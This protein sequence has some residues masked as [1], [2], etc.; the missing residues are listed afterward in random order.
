M[1][2]N[3]LDKKPGQLKTLIDKA[4]GNGEGERCHVSCKEA[5]RILGTTETIVWGLVKAKHLKTSFKMVDGHKRNTFEKASI[6]HFKRNYMLSRVIADR[7][8]VARQSI[9]QRLRTL[10]IYPISGPSINGA[11]T[12]V[13]K[14]SD[15]SHLTKPKVHAAKICSVKSIGL[16]RTKIDEKDYFTMKSAAKYLDIGMRAVT[17]LTQG[18]VLNRVDLPH[19]NVLIER[20]S[21]YKLIK[22]INDPKY[23]RLQ[24]IRDKSALSPTVFW[25]YFINTGIV[26]IVQLFSWQLVHERCVRKLDAL[27]LQYVTET[28]GNKMLGKGSGTLTS[29]RKTGEV[30]FKKFPGRSRDVY[31]YS[32]ESIENLIKA[33]ATGP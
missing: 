2:T 15:L 4:S 3:L 7:F 22:K 30:E 24:D 31:L 5:A 16:A 1:L 8:D 26:K 28:E 19:R 17:K 9:S 18:G 33:K 21:V 23:F 11:I 14:I 25:H 6:E 27:L 10:K 13:F 29:L 20:K 12:N 32:I